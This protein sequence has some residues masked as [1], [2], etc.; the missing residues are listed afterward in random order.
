MGADYNHDARLGGVG[1]VFAIVNR[2]VI[3]C[4]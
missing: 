3:A 2:A 1:D 4:M